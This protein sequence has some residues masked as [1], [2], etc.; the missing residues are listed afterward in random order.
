LDSYVDKSVYRVLEEYSHKK[1]FVI[2]F[3][4]IFGMYRYC[5]QSFSFFLPKNAGKRQWP[6]KGERRPWGCSEE[7]V[8]GPRQKT[9]FW[10]TH[11]LA[12][13]SG[14]KSKREPF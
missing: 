9:F 8:L 11:C 4:N 5:E 12:R 1:K 7:Q 13:K 6:N 2:P 10:I 14:Y 3:P